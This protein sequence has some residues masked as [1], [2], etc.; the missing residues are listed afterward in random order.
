ML[1]DLTTLATASGP[2]MEDFRYGD[3]FLLIVGAIVGTV[4]AAA[5][6]LYGAWCLKETVRGRR[7]GQR[8]VARA[9]TGVAAFAFAGC[10]LALSVWMADRGGD[11]PQEIDAHN[12]EALSAAFPGLTVTAQD[13]ECAAYAA[14][15]YET[16]PVSHEVADRLVQWNWTVV[17][18][19]VVVSG[20]QD[21]TFRTD[22]QFRALLKG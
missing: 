4:A 19:R 5:F 2:T 11:I 12:K 8:W 16:C 7:A 13:V 17:D 3:P 6:M 1:T 21:R 10:L 14:Q 22:S 18:D 15:T 9:S 20:P